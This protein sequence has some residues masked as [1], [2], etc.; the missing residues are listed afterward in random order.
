MF[1]GPESTFLKD[2]VKN[3]TPI[4]GEGVLN[5]PPT[6]RLVRG[7]PDLGPGQI[8][9]VSQSETGSFLGLIDVCITQLKAQGPS[10]TLSGVIKE[11]KR[12]AAAGRRPPGHTPRRACPRGTASNLNTHMT[13]PMQAFGRARTNPGRAAGRDRPHDLASILRRAPLFRRT[14]ISVNKFI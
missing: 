6:A 8:N 3:E 2:V 1:P 5:L 9:V 10:R 4:S 11:K 12:P 13:C 14:P 7:D